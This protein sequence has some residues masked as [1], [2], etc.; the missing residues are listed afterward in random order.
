MGQLFVSKGY[1]Q[2]ALPRFLKSVKLHLKGCSFDDFLAALDQAP[3]LKFV[4]RSIL[5]LATSYKA[6]IDSRNRLGRNLLPPVSFS[7]DKISKVF[8][9]DRN[10]VFWL[11]ARDDPNVHLLCYD[12]DDYKRSHT[13]VTSGVHMLLSFHRVARWPPELKEAVKAHLA[14]HGTYQE[15]KRY[16]QYHEARGT[17]L[18]EALFFCA[19]QCHINPLFQDWQDKVDLVSPTCSTMFGKTN[20]VRIFVWTC[21]RGTI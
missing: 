5:S 1:L 21:L 14:E 7:S 4:C 17:R 8:I 11:Q 6:S 9:E 18:R 10:K 16:A 19:V 15:L 3:V 12:R 13:E 2:D 20:N